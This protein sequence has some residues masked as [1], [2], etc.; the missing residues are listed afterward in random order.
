MT[1]SQAERPSTVVEEAEERGRL[2]TTLSRLGIPGFF[3]VHTHFLPPNVMAKVRAVFDSAGPLIGR[4]WPLN[5]RDTDDVLVETLR[6]FGV[7]R[8]SALAYAHKPAMAE[9]LNE[10]SAGFA[11]RVPE[12]LHC[13]TFFPEEGA[14]DYVSARIS[15]GVELFKVHVQVGGFHVTDPLLDDAWGVLAEAG[16][17]IVLHAGSGPVPT[18]FTGPGPVRELLGRH[19]GLA[20]VMAHMGAPEYVEF[21]EMA[22]EFANVRLDTTMAF[23]DFFEEMGG[24]FPPELTSRLHALGDKVLLGS[25]FP[26][27][28]YPYAHQIEALERL[29][30]GDDWLR[31]VLWG[32]GEALFGGSA[33]PGVSS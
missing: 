2:E 23:T 4:P 17:P 24:P 18:E 10:W 21:M 5:Y 22:E 29:D 12:A 30:L 9:F 16:T 14:A 28:P 3:D 11:Q 27:I 1:D 15:S 13:G 31:R 32:N 25:D 20:L 6:G 7:R 8:F 26:N 33:A 19:P